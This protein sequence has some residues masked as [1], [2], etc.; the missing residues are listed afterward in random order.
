MLIPDIEY[1]GHQWSSSPAL[2][3]H[4]PEVYL[5]FEHAVIVVEDFYYIVIFLNKNHWCAILNLMKIIFKY[6]IDLWL[7][8]IK[9]KF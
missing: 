8:Y 3:A 6:I 4:V 9:D 2:S 5:G 7:F 1:R